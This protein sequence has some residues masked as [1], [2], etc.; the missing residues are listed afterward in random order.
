VVIELIDHLSDER[1]CLAFAARGQR[2]FDDR[3]HASSVR[4]RVK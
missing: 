4:E 3:D 1:I 2:H